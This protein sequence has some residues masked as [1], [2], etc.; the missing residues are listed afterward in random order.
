M[1]ACMYIFINAGA[2]MS[3]GKVAAQ[4]AHAAID[5][6]AETKD[7]D[8]IDAWYLGWHTTKIV[9]HADDAEHLS[10][11]ERYLNDRGFETSLVIDEGRTEIGA[12]TPTALGVAIVDKDDPHTKATFEHFQ[13][14]RD[15]KPN[16]NP[17]CPGCV[18]KINA[19]ET[20]F[21]ESAKPDM[22]IDL[23]KLIT[24]GKD[25]LDEKRFPDEAVKRFSQFLK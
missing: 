10:N 1:N 22:E 6:Y 7:Q 2:K 24:F 17:W 19:S 16:E 3:Q 18:D 23:S 25:L 15:P 9:L 8:L 12:F 13:L 11:I 14:L 21:T 4:A 5:A 20:A